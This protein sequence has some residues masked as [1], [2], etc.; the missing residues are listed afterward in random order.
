M[1]HMPTFRQTQ[2]LCLYVLAFLLCAHAEHAYS[3]PQRYYT[4]FTI[5]DVPDHLSDEADLQHAILQV[6]LDL[7]ATL[8]NVSNVEYSLSSSNITIHATNAI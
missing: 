1:T 5:V 4:E 2:K 3:T 6:L 7:T 8:S